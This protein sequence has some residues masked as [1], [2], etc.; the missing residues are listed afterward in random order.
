MEMI[1]NKVTPVHQRVPL[2]ASISCHH[3]SILAENELQPALEVLKNYPEIDIV[4]IDFVYD[5]S[6]NSFVSSHD[7][8]DE[9]MKKGS[10]LVDWIEAMVSLNKILWIDIKDVIT[11]FLGWNLFSKFNAKAFSSLIRQ[12]AIVWTEKGVNL[13]DH[14]IIGCQWEWLY[15]DIQKRLGISTRI[16]H[17][18][19]YGQAYVGS[20]LCGQ[21]CRPSVVENVQATMLRDINRNKNMHIVCI[22]HS[23]FTDVRDLKQFLDS[24]PSHVHQCVLY[25]YKQGEAHPQDLANSDLN[26]IIQYD[27]KT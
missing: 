21:C 14:I 23:F 25:S 2:A 9:L 19:P 10:S 6:N 8:S 5:A 24:L 3:G 15:K 26:V 27:Y 18:L 17:D 1:A 11:T 22:D 4:E 20:V 7:Y 13:Y 16:V 12:Q